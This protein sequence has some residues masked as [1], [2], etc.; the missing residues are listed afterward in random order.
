MIQ[1]LLQRIAERFHRAECEKVVLFIEKSILRSSKKS[2]QQIPRI[3]TNLL[4]VAEDKRFLTH[5][6]YDIKGIIRAIIKRLVSN[7]IEGAS[8][9]EQQLVRVITVRYE[10]SMKRKIRELAI[11]SLIAK[12]FGKLEIANTYL[13][14]AYF[15]TS[16]NGYYAA[17]RNLKINPKH[18]SI[19]DAASVIARLKY[20]ESAIFSIKKQNNIIRR[21]K[22]IL[23]MYYSINKTQINKDI[24]ND[25]NQV[26]QSA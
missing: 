26:Y 2:T 23:S 13:S 20:P 14:I 5:S 4:I 1:R 7:K 6:G 11:A 24:I 18:I 16:M 15:G 17:C 9:I 8:T 21:S 12:K 25:T 10:I 22:Y 3:V 19:E